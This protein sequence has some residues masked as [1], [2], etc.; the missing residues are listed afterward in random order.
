MIGDFVNIISGYA[1][2]SNL[3]NTEGNGMPIVRIRDVGR[4]K[5]E[6]FY[7]GEY[8]DAYVLGY[9]DF[10]V[11]MDGD[12]RLSEWK[13]PK[14]LLNQ[15]VCKIVPNE[16]IINSRYL[17]YMLPKE[18][19]R[20]EDATS[21]VTV[22]HLSVKKIKEIEIPLPPLATQQKIAA[23]LDEADK[24]RQLNKQLIEKYDALT[25][26]LFL[27]M[28]G[29]PVTNPKGWGTKNIEELVIKEKGS[30]KR[31]PFGGALK[32]EIFV[33]EGYLVYEQFHALNNDFTMARYF[34]DELKYKELEG[35]AVKPRDIIV[36]C[37]GVYLGK[38]AIVPDDAR[39]GIIN[40]ALLKITLDQ[41]KMRNNFFLFHFTQKNFRE[42][43]FNANRGAGIPNFPPMS[44][45]KRF[46]FIAPPIETQDQFAERVQAIEQQKAQAQAS[47]QKSEAL[48][49]SLLQRAF[50]GEIA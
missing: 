44:D 15:R 14:A 17:L 50:K 26:S 47:L 41:K 34:I 23:I 42:T 3:F 31:G 27:D 18:L 28:F 33:D 32:K 7:D 19:K 38:L 49:Q 20:I 5:T 43:Y 45:F 24:V 6:T 40:Q 25:Q 29:D 30:I 35:F 37:S 36:S 12:F 2:K 9:G 4:D 46:P 11:G 8:P 1:F 10:L 39:A 21:Y 22:K 48:F 13:G 16:E